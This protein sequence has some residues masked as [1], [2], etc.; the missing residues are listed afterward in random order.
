A[1]PRNWRKAVRAVAESG[2]TYVTVS[3][4]EILDAL[5]YT[6]RLSGVFGEPAAVA[7]VAGIAA[8]RRENIIAPQESVVAVITGNGLKDIRTAIQAAGKTYDIPPTLEAVEAVVGQA[9]TR[10]QEG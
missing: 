5:R 6:P 7:S 1:V 4:D 9:S 3:D 2:G 10:A 8:A